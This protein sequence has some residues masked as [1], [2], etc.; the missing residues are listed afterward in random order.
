MG[1]VHGRRSREPVAEVAIQIRPMGRRTRFET[2]PM[3]YACLNCGE[4][5]HPGTRVWHDPDLDESL[6]VHCWPETLRTVQPG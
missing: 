2:R 6:C 4:W 3:A 5:I 1:I